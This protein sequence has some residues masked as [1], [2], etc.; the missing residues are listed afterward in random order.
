MLG[1]DINKV[2]E[3]LLDKEIKKKSEDEFIFYNVSQEKKLHQLIE[4]QVIL[5]SDNSHKVM[6]I[7]DKKSTVQYLCMKIAE[8]MEKFH[9]FANLEGLKAINLTKRTEKGTVKIPNSGEIKDFIV[10][11]DVI[12]CDLSTQ[13]YWVKTV[14]K[15]HSNSSRLIITMD[16]KHRLDTYFKKLKFLLTKLAINFWADYAK[17]QAD[18]CHY[19]FTSMNFKTLKSKNNFVYNLSD[20][21]KT[22]YLDESK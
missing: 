16:I 12:Y 2:K 11:D 4:I 8:K 15:L 6:V 3:K 21:V 5:E 17:G 9:Q 20:I 22:D 14:I 13:E 19:I 18:N 10:C 1:A 7:I